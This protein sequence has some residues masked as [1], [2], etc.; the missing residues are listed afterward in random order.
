MGRVIM[1]GSSEI[2]VIG[3]PELRYLSVETDGSIHGPDK[4]RS[5]EDGMSAMELNVHQNDLCEIA[6]ASPFH[7]QIMDGLPLRSGCRAC[8]ER[9]TCAGGHLPNRYS[10][11]RGFDN[12]SVWCADLLALFAHVRKRLGVSHAETRRRRK[13]L[14][15]LR[16]RSFVGTA[17]E[18][19]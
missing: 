16:E 13:E 10:K 5:C 4:L 14:A 15:R 8:P 19:S 7:A 9:D 1:G 17:A 18:S 6:I 11:A 12:P 2:D 3:N